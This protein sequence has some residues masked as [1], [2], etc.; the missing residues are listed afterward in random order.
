MCLALLRH[1]DAFRNP[2]ALGS[3]GILNTSRTRDGAARFGVLER[4]SSD[5]VVQSQGAC[6]GQV[7][8]IEFGPFPTERFVSEPLCPL[9]V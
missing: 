3:Y 7:R 5:I 1:N 9:V 4:R 6:K 8:N 2:N